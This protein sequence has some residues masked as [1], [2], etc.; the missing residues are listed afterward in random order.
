VV[1]ITEKAVSDQLRIPQY[2]F[3]LLVAVGGLLLWF[4]LLIDLLGSFGKLRRSEP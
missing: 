1:G 3:K 4:E 2:P